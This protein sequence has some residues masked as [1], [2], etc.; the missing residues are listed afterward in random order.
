MQLKLVLLVAILLIVSM[1]HAQLDGFDKEMQNNLELKENYGSICTSLN[2]VEFSSMPK[3]EVSLQEII[4]GTDDSGI[5]HIPSGYYYLDKPLQIT[6]NLTAIGEGIVVVDAHRAYKVLDINNLQ[7]DIKL[8]NIK[9]VNGKGDYGGAISSRAKSLSLMNCT[10]SSNLAYYGAGVYQ[11]EG[12]LLVEDSTFDYN[13][14]ASEGGAVYY[15]DSVAGN[16][17]T[18]DAND[19]LSPLI[20]R[21]TGFYGNNAGQ[22][23]TAIYS[24]SRGLRLESSVFSKNNGTSPIFAMDGQIVVRGCNISNNLGPF[25]RQWGE[26]DEVSIV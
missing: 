7:A 8:K 26:P 5:V 3:P 10:F 18:R 4:D 6:E 25:G 9:F 2:G 17:A 11:K 15:N 16:T 13:Y 24:D 19:G 12:S 20:I 23:G 21:D 1:A 14:A 22:V